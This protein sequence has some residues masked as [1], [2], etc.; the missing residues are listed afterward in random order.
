MVNENIQPHEE[1]RPDEEP[2]DINKSTP[3]YSRRNG[4]Q[5]KSRNW[6]C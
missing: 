4:E 3:C 6:S 1:K 2:K 5:Y